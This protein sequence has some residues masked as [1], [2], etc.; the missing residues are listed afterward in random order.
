MPTKIKIPKMYTVYE[1]SIGEGVMGTGMAVPTGL[2]DYEWLIQCG[3]REFVKSSLSV[4][5]WYP[6]RPHVHQ[7]R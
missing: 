2:G 1:V 6:L 3:T 4:L 7:L 5:G